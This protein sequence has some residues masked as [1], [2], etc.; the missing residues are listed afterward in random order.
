MQKDHDREIFEKEAK[1]NIL[2]KRI[3]MA[4]ERLNDRMELLGKRL[5]AL[6]AHFEPA[7]D[8]PSVGSQNAPGHD[9]DFI[10]VQVGT[11]TKDQ[12]PDAATPRIKI[13]GFGSENWPQ[14]S[15]SPDAKKKPGPDE[16]EAAFV[17]MRMAEK[18]AIDAKLDFED[19]CRD[20]GIDHLSYENRKI[21]DQYIKSMGYARVDTRPFYEE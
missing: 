14:Q 11:Q 12:S 13:I 8:Q 9:D 1:L 3:Q 20:A 5:D 7:G 16:I 19:I 2:D 17:K 4:T 18:S 6:A 21:M 10:T 15:D